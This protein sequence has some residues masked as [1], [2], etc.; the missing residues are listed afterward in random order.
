MASCEICGKKT[1]FGNTVKQVRTGLYSRTHRQIHPNLQRATLMI[2]GREKRVTACT[3]CI[4]TN[5]I[6]Q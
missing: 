5:R 4:R 2:D 3:R 1:V 6:R